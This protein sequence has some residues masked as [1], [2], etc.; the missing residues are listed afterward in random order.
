MSSNNTR[1]QRQVLALAL[2]VAA[3]SV[4]AF[5]TERINLSTLSDKEPV[6]GF[7]VTYLAGSAIKRNA[8]AMQQSLDR[9]A[10]GAFGRAS[11]LGLHHERTLGIG[12]ELVTTDRPLDRL[13]A[14]TLMRQI[15]ADP[16]VTHIEPNARFY[17][18]LTPNDAYFGSQYSLQNGIGGSNAN[19]AWDTG[20]RGA[21]KIVA[22]IDTGYRPHVDLNANIINGYDF[23]TNPATANNGNGRDASA[24]DPGDW[25]EAGA[26]LPRLHSH[27]FDMA[28]HSRRRH[29]G[30]GG[31]QRHRRR[32]HGLQRQGAGGACAR[33]LW[34][35]ARRYRRCHHLVLRWHGGRSAGG[36]RQ[37]GERHQHESGPQWHLCIKLSH[38]GGDHRR[39]Q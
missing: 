25:S 21:G 24:L 19:L 11:A 13:E 37:P 30:S 17:P 34:R 33:S 27:V 38:A 3:L 36:W 32:R 10:S 2:S 23:I 6:D 18:T 7:I 8:A 9:A 28:R 26:V 4:P 35:N 1:L 39:P 14:E 31:Q 16:D 29:G 15:A 12:S 5:A 22:V 20:F